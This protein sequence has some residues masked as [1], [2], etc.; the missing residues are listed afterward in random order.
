MNITLPVPAYS[1]NHTELE[2]ARSLEAHLYKLSDEFLKALQLSHIWASKYFFDGRY[3]D[4]TN[5]L[6]WKEI[7]VSQNLYGEFARLFLEPIKTNTTKPIHC[8][9]QADPQ[10]NNSLLNKIYHQGILSGFNIM[11]IH[12]DHI[13]NYGFGSTQRIAGVNNTLPSQEELEMFCLYLRE[14]IH[15]IGKM[16]KLVLGNTGKAFSPPLKTRGYS[17]TPIPRSFLFTCNN[18]ESN[19]SRRQII[20]LSLL[21]QGYGQKDIARIM[22]ISPRT[23]EFHFDQIKLKFYNPS[24]AEMIASFKDSP[25]VCI[26]PFIMLETNLETNF[27]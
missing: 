18:Y 27:P 26:N 5:D 3:M 4:V 25:L 8:T 11:I 12:S 10:E 13:E 14:G 20:C 9:W 21:A 22:D 19:L 6:S 16:R 7:M 23:V 17:F 24:K 15:K 1:T 2:Q